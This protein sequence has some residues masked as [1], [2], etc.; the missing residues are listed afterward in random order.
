[1]HM[2]HIKA[3]LLRNAFLGIRRVH[4]PESRSV[5]REATMD[6]TNACLTVEK[7]KEISRHFARSQVACKA[8]IGSDLHSITLFGDEFGTSVMRTAMAAKIEEY[9]QDDRALSVKLIELARDP[10][11][12]RV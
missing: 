2:L 12:A 1:M 5:D 11:I 7:E 10:R 6:Q 9:M 8:D 4:V 3:T